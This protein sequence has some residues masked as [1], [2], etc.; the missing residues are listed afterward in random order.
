[1]IEKLK[2]LG[3]KGYEANAYISLL[4]LGDAEANEIALEAGIPMGR[5]Y[6]V[7]SSLEE[8]H[9]IRSQDIRPKRFACVDPL[10]AMERLSNNKK[11]EI[12]HA[13]AEIERLA[14]DLAYELSG[15]KTTR[16]QKTF[17]TVA[18]GDESHELVRESISGAKKEILFFLASRIS[19]ERI[20]QRILNDTYSGIINA[21][22]RTIKNGIKVKMI[23]NKNV[24]FSALEKIPA[25]RPLL[26]HSG[27]EFA[28]RLAAI[29]STPFDI[30]D[31]EIVSL[32]MLNPID[33]EDLFAV[34]NIRD[35][36]LAGELRKKFF[37]IWDKAEV[38]HEE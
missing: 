26:E 22:Q 36:K 37:E 3:L 6:D 28:C 24:D 19:S 30:I 7:L 38:Y 27:D 21:L 12:K 25:V 11:E 4:K 18:I 35:M 2:R 31:G 1:M 34:V 14:H 17:W 29:P 23:L 16:P 8:A 20:K 13:E 32:K 33:P 9:L 5:I 10:A 15:I